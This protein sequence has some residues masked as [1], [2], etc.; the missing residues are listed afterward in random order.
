MPSN[1]AILSCPLLLLPSFF[2]SIRVFSRVSSAS[3]GQGTRASASD[4]PVNIQDWFPLT[5]T[6]LI[7]LLSK[8]LS[9]VSSS[10]TSQ[11]TNPLALYRKGWLVPGMDFD[12]LVPIYH[13]I[14][15]WP[16]SPKPKAWRSGCLQTVKTALMFLGICYRLKVCNSAMWWYLGGGASAE[17]LV[18]EDRALLSGISALIR[19]PR[20]PPK[21]LPP[22]QVTET[23]QNPGR[24]PSPGTRSA[25]NLSL[26][27]DYAKAFDCV[28][29]NK[30]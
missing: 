20:E 3:G 8:G 21:P 18:H 15:W 10:T 1:H 25:R 19:Y 4:H 30:L 29:H 11:E 17:W 23:R 2:P 12:V 16:S 6:C 22:C 7:S 26:V 13:S 14:A 9:K 28:D 24:K 27:I 5:L